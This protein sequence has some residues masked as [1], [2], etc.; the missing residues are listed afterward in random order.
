MFILM[1]LHGVSV[2]AQ[3]GDSLRQ[4]Q[5]DSAMRNPVIPGLQSPDLTKRAEFTEENSVIVLPT[6][7][8]PALSKTLQQVEYRGW[9]NGRIF[10]NTSTN[11]Y[12]VEMIEDPYLRVFFF[13]KN[14]ERIVE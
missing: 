2:R 12:K 5:T 6:E 3:R 1:M 11:E 10:R 8:P 9:E 13:D 7:I 4:Q 14:G